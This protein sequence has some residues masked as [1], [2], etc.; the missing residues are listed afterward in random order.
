MRAT[1]SA[2]SFDELHEEFNDSDSD[3]ANVS[4]VSSTTQASTSTPGS[5]SIKR[6]CVSTEDRGAKIVISFQ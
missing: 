3:K 4:E 2:V 5:K 1:T 6:K